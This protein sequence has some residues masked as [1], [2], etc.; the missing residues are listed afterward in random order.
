MSTG[1]QH[2]PNMLSIAVVV[3]QT[4]LTHTPREPLLRMLRISIAG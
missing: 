2:E 3:P 4:P 1:E